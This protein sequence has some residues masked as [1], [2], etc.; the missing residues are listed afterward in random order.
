MRLYKFLKHSEGNDDSVK[1]RAFTINLVDKKV[2]EHRKIV[3][4]MTEEYELTK[5]ACRL[6]DEL[7]RC[8]KRY[9]KGNLVFDFC[10]EE[11]NSFGRLKENVEERI[12]KKWHKVNMEL[13]HIQEEFEKVC[14][15][16]EN[17]MV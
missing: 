17:K 7:N 2:D 10:V 3:E 6:V 13:S 9:Y 14:L 4:K 8:L 15:H 1:F 5:D 12:R 16:N 11:K